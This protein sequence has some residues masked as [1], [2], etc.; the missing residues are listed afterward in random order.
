VIETDFI[1][2][3]ACLEAVKM[4]S[5]SKI[6]TKNTIFLKSDKPLSL[7]LSLIQ[8]SNLIQLLLLESDQESNLLLLFS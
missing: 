6:R 7:S 4:Q 3:K 1:D 5:S 2:C 8:A